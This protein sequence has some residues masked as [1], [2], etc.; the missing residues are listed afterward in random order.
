VD[1]VVPEIVRTLRRFTP[2]DK[3]DQLLLEHEGR[4]GHC[5]RC[6]MVS[7]CTLW[8]AAIKARYVK[9]IQ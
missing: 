7:P 4:D 6:H 1:A 9:K 2:V 5:A 3:L 8:N